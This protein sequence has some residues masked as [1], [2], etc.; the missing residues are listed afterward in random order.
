MIPRYAKLLVKIYLSLCL[1]MLLWRVLNLTLVFSSVSTV[2]WIDLLTSFGLGWRFD[3]VIICALL[4]F[5]FLILTFNHFT[6]RWDWLQRK[7]LW[8]VYALFPF[9]L[10]L[11]I[12]D[13]FYFEQFRLR[14]TSVLLNW[15]DDITFATKM[16]MQDPVWMIG[17]FIFP[18]VLWVLSRPFAKWARAATPTLLLGVKQILWAFCSILIVGLLFVGIRGR[19]AIKSPLRE[20]VAYFSDNP[21][22][23]QLALNPIY[24]FASSVVRA[25][26]Y[27]EKSLKFMSHESAVE[28]FKSHHALPVGDEP[29]SHDTL[30]APLKNWNVI[31]VIMEGMSAHY[32]HY[33]KNPSWTPVLDR[34]MSEGLEFTQAYSAG[35]HTYNGVWST[36]FS[37]PSPYAVHP[38]KRDVIPTLDSIPEQWKKLG[39]ETLFFT[40]HDEHFDNMAGFLRQNGFSQIIAQDAYPSERVFSILGVP[41]HDMYQKALQVLD[42]TSAPFFAAMLTG[43]NHKPHVIPPELRDK[44]NAQDM[45][46]NIVRYSD[47]ALGYLIENAKNKIWFKDTLFVVLADHGHSVG[48]TP[49]DQIL[50][51]HHM[52][53][54]FWSPTLVGTHK[55]IDT[56]V[57][58]IDV[59]P[60]IAGLVGGPVKNNSM[61]R[62]ALTQ[63][64]PWVYIVKDNGACIR[65]SSLL[66]CESE[67]GTITRYPFEKSAWPDPLIDPKF[68]W[69]VVHAELQLSDWL[70]RQ[71]PKAK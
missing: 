45:E 14:I 54:I 58:Q 3:N 27:K 61:G 44:F 67:E 21:T 11:Q 24:T 10:T 36:L 5:P 38:L 9:V 26:K 52:P 40:T 25:R 4:T 68:A 31:V 65:F 41:D 30:T 51:Y 70:L 69:P 71:L 66:E 34:L 13:L 16:V 7:A 15:L 43:S 12:I 49:M 28:T 62:D 57:S 46:E 29:F 23:N 1:Y 64:R 33:K 18:I 35:T 53:L 47:W 6:G 50:S 63:P 60:T 37:F 59:L 55:K 19:V 22:L 56:P 20:G 42:S 17:F 8:P 2:S 48:S 39:R 32:S